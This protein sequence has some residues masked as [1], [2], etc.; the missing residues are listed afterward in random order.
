[1]AYF[2]LGF[3][4]FGAWYAFLAFH[5]I[6]AIA[7]WM[8]TSIQWSHTILA[9]MAIIDFMAVVVLIPF[10]IRSFSIN[11]VSSN[12]HYYGDVELGNT[13]QQ[14]QVLSPWYLVPFQLF[15]CN[16]GNS[17]AIHH[18]VVRDPFYIREL[19]VKKAH[20]IMREMG[21]RFNDTDT[22]FRANSFNSAGYS[23]RETQMPL[24][25]D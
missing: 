12:M 23:T 24:L 2:P 17:H 25:L 6:D 21:V 14:T 8:G 1:M 22:F 13:L 4:Y 9:N 20:K 3:L 5:A 18:F 15:C 19:T 16:F 10:A 11:L 7:L